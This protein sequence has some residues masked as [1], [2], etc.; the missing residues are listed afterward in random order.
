MSSNLYHSY[1]FIDGE[2]RWTGGCMRVYRYTCVSAQREQTLPKQ[3]RAWLFCTSRK[4]GTVICHLGRIIS[5][6]STM[7]SVATLWHPRWAGDL[8]TYC[9]ESSLSCPCSPFLGLNNSLHNQRFTTLW[10]SFKV[11]AGPFVPWCL[12]RIHLFM[13]IASVTMQIFQSARQKQ[14]SAN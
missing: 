8:S 2:G 13:H 1:T 6:G 7:P 5:L 10:R 11:P 3:T 12:L 9:A 14:V 4:Q